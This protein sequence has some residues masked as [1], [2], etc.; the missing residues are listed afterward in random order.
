[1]IGE[2]H[3]GSIDRGLPA[4]GIQGAE[5]Q[6][7]RADAYRYYLENGF[8]RPEI[9]GMH[10]FQWN[11]QPVLGRSDGENYNI[12]FMNICGIPYPELTEGASI[13][14]ERMYQVANLEIQ[15]FSKIIKK[16]PQI[17]Y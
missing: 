17:Y 16:I 1:M 3:F 12:G 9:I 6:Q 8:A 13:T 14:H 7:A 4:T 15:P 10:Y 2:F 5:N 11:D